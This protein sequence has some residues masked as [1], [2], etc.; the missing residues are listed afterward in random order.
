MHVSA[1]TPQLLNRNPKHR[2]GAQRDAAELK[3]HPF[4]KLIDW[5]ALAAREVSP[6]FK[7]Y[8]ESDES[9]ANFDVRPDRLSPG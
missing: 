5:V 1:L 6:P 4:F 3:E 8:V 7:P 9:V 2:L